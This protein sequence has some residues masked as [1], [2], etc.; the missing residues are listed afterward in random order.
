MI[1]KRNF[2]FRGSCFCEKYNIVLYLN[3]DM[4]VVVIVRCFGAITV[5]YWVTICSV[6][7]DTRAWNIHNSTSTGPCLTGKLHLTPWHHSTILPGKLH[8]TPWHHSTILPGKLHLTPWHHSTILPGKLHLTPWHH[9]T[10]ST[11]EVTLK[12]WHHS[13]MSTREV[14]LNTL[15]P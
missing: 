6:V 1:T 9:S 2:I 5:Y 12:R 10:M 13:T 8:L 4:L 11:R 7:Q 3:K 14:T 15:A